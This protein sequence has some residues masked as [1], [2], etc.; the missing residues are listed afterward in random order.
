MCEFCESDEYKK[1]LIPLRSTYADDNTCEYVSPS[2][3]EE[4]DIQEEGICYRGI[5]SCENC[6]GCADGN[7]V[8]KMNKFS[9]NQIG[10]E[11]YHKIKGLLIAPFSESLSV[12]FCPWC[13]RR[14]VDD[15]DFVEFHKCVI[16][17]VKEDK[18]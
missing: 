12:N 7:Y 10:I 11:F 2:N 6:D 15:K 1:Y 17:G 13:G 16:G 4:K 14:V 9:R 3:Y 5:M 8:F 18:E